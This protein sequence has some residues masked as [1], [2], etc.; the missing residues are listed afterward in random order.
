MHSS[1]FWGANPWSFHL[2]W[3]VQSF[4]VLFQ[5]VTVSLFSKYV[6]PIIRSPSLYTIACQQVH[7]NAYVRHASSWHPCILRNHWESGPVYTVF[8]LWFYRQYS[9]PQDFVCDLTLHSMKAPSHCLSPA[10]FYVVGLFGT[11]FAQWWTAVRSEVNAITELSTRGEGYAQAN[12]TTSNAADPVLSHSIPRGHHKRFRHHAWHWAFYVSWTKWTW[13]MVQRFIRVC[14][15]SLLSMSGLIITSLEVLGTCVLMHSGRS[16][17]S[18]YC[19][20]FCWLLL[21]SWIKYLRYR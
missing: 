3:K 15:H 9:S 10:T 20:P 14:F 16:L 13:R 18:A 12:W 2:F 6:L 8:V 7:A 11:L 5:L 4:V 21:M 19:F 17:M 1:V